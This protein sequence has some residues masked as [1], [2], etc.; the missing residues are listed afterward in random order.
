[1]EQSGLDLA[2]WIREGFGDG[3]PLLIVRSGNGDEND[4]RRAMEYYPIQA[5]YEKSKL[6]RTEHYRTAVIQPCLER[7]RLKST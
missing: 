6:F 7:L 5:Y 3:F 4:A 2:K 1:M